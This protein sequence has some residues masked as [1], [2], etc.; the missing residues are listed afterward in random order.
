LKF[1][2]ISDFNMTNIEG[3]SNLLDNLTSLKYISLYNIEVSE[4]FLNEKNKELNNIDNL[5][6]CQNS[7]IITNLNAIK[8]CCDFKTESCDFTNYIIVYYGQNDTD[9]N[10]SFINEY[11]NNISFI[12][13]DNIILGLNNKINIKNNSKIEIHFSS[14]LT[15]L[16]SFFDKRYDEKWLI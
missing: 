10:L 4:L 13:H 12:I 1:L 3:A 8:F 16:E 2:D 9:Y 14:P 11:R 7:D 15:S 6:V 5:I